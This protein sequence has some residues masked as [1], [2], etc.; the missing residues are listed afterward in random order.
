MI[1]FKHRGSFNN[2]EKFLT[3]SSKLDLQRI[4]EPYAKEGIEALRAATPID[5]GETASAWNYSIESS[6]KSFKI[7]WSNGN[8]V[9]GVPIAIIL[10]YGHGTG[11]GGYVEGRDYIN[12]AMKPVFDKISERLMEEVKQ[13]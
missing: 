1:H 8:I 13:L 12:P 3:R 11:W 7:I 6:G 10:Q 9:K 4:I 5:S 2:L